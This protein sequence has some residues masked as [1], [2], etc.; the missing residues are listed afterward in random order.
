MIVV[1]DLL[2]AISLIE[3]KSCN[4]FFIVEAFASHGIGT[5]VSPSIMQSQRI[6]HERN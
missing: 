4:S 1:S 3:F 5:V 2:T 6:E